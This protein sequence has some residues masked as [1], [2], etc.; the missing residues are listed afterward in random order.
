MCA[1][2]IFESEIFVMNFINE[3]SIGAMYKKRLVTDVLFEAELGSWNYTGEYDKAA[4]FV[5]DHQVTN[6]ALWTTFVEQFRLQLDSE[7]GGWRGEYYGKMMRGA[8][9]IYKYTKNEKLYRTL[10]STVRYLLSCQEENGRI[11]SYKQD[12]EFGYWDMW[13]RKYVLL[14]SQYFYEICKDEELKAEII[15][16]LNRHLDYIID[17]V[18]EGDGQIDILDTTTHN[19][20]TWGALNSSSIL[21][22]VVRQYWLT[23]NE[24]YLEFAAYIVKRG[25][26]KWGNIYTLAI[27]GK[28]APYEYPV[29]KAYEAT[30]FFEGVLE[31]YRATGDEDAK[32]AYINFMAKVVETDLTAIGCSGCTHE[33]FDHSSLVQ[34][35]VNDEVKQET[36]VTVTLLKA[37]YQALCLTGEA[38]YAEAM[39]RSGYNAMLG[40]VNFNK[41]YAM[42]NDTEVMKM[43]NFDKTAPF[44]RLIEGFTFDSYSPLYK[45][46]RS[47][48]I[49]G[50]KIMPGGTSYG[51]CACIGASGIAVMPI[52][53][54]MLKAGGIVI[55]HYMNGTFTAGGVALEMETKYPYG[56]KISIKVHTGAPVRFSLDLRIPS[57]TI[58]KSTIDGKVAEASALG[59]ATIEREW[60]EGDTVELVI[61]REFTTQRL[62]GKVAV[63]H[64]A[65]VMALDERNQDIDVKV[66]DKII[67]IEPM[68]T[69]FASREAYKVTF[70]NG[71]SVNMTDYASAGK[72]WNKPNC[73]VTVW[74]DEEV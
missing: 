33:L 64:G 68:V 72:E 58:G 71:V 65:I 8:C 70:S 15:A 52:S 59:Y 63:T 69:N 35:E 48:R 13:C 17:R 62:N 55:N 20:Y 11:S 47:R 53:S 28:K 30:S 2:Q 18:G 39:E 66:T 22:P 9:W 74:I 32:A 31:Y 34:T 44:V 51:C 60:C 1:P 27:E 6:P 36:C 73:R 46:K 14:G 50:F 40:S 29:T 16:K 23:G 24:K 42:P 45:D 49:G 38:K 10:E 3:A 43:H 37:F 5:E 19:P 12:K 21:E 56:E 7:D 25:G 41:I 67:K 54:V 4:R 61:P 26:S 57:A